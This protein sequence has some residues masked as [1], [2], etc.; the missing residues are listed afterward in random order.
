M[1]LYIKNM[2]CERCKM[3]VKTE[4]EKLGLHPIA[5]QLGE[6]EFSVELTAQEIEAVQSALTQFGFELIDDRKSRVI[7]KIKTLIIDLVHHQYHKLPVNLSEYI[8]EHIPMDYSYISSLFTQVENTTIEH[9]YIRQ[10]IEKV[11]ELLV[12]DELNLNEISDHLNYSS[13]SHLS[14]QFKKITGVTPLHF[15]RLKE[16]KRIPIE[17]L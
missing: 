4:L 2:V 1:K 15:K 7:N 12:Y 8:V 14:K 6:A 9:F 5:V 10:K 3:V 17:N 16:Q 13:A 11:K